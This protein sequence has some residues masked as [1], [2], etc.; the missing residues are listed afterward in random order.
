[1]IFVSMEEVVAALVLPVP[2][3]YRTRT[4]FVT[5]G[6]MTR[7]GT[8][9]VNTFREWNSSLSLMKSNMFVASSSCVRMGDLAQKVAT[10]EEATGM[11]PS[12]NFGSKVELVVVIVMECRF[13][14]EYLIT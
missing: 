5:P 9:L 4:F 11:T 2:K 13:L 6:M 8:M 10:D 7:N 1:M 3:P 12:Q 14:K